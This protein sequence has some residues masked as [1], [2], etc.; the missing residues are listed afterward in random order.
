MVILI[1]ASFMTVNRKPTARQSVMLARRFVDTHWNT[2][3]ARILRYQRA[4]LCTAGSQGTASALLMETA[5][6]AMGDCM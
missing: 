1:N 6:W 5:G 3:C 4:A 2:R